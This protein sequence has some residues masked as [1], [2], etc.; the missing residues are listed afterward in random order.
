ML[1]IE[2]WHPGLTPTL[3]SWHYYPQFLDEHTKAQGG[4]VS[5]PA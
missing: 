1:D 4:E 2:P 5:D 3:E